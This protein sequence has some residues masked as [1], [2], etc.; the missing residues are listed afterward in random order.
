MLYNFGK[1][2][3]ILFT[4]VVAALFFQS[5][6]LGNKGYK[7]STGRTNEILIVTNSDSLWK[8]DVGDSI[9]AL[10]GYEM[11]GLP[12]PE[13]AFEMIHLPA[14]GFLQMYQS[15]HNIFILDINQGFDTTIV[16]T[17]KDFWSKPQRIVKISVPDK[18]SCFKELNK[19]RD[20]I[21][22]LFDETE[23]QRANIT[24][25]SVEDIKIR[26]QLEKNYKFSMAFP[27]SFYIA[28]TTG[29]FVWIRREAEKYSQGVFI[30]FYPYTD[31]IAFNPERIIQLRD[32]ITKMY[33]PGPSAGSYMKSA[34]IMP[35]M[36]RNINFNNVFAIETR[37]LW[38]LEGNFMGG[39]FVS[40]TFLDSLHSRIVN[41]DGYVYFPG[42]D[43]KNL[44]RQVES[45]LYTFE[46][47]N[48][49]IAEKTKN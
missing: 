16:E 5:C 40:Y 23:R 21:I 34:T 43:K 11:D 27:K 39:P 28:T 49:D 33:I 35:P 37:G 19:N 42:Q 20:D 18:N 47:L 13:N 8:S 14:S 22:P 36:F 10:F 1:R 41:V 7:P 31:T 2:E 4:V 45:I 32:S 17:K 46:P 38:E 29:N 25:A 48:A 24:F 15:H 6:N 30:Y 26:K 44:L 3:F 9:R 12:Q